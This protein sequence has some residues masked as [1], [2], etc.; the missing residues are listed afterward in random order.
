MIKCNLKSYIFAL[1]VLA[2][3]LHRGSTLFSLILA[4]A[5][6]VSCQIKPAWSISNWLDFTILL[7]CDCVFVK[8]FYID[9]VLG[10][11]LSPDTEETAAKQDDDPH[12]ATDDGNIDQRWWQSN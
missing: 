8:L 1:G 3:L 4:S 7:L 6:V 2:P 12:G 9:R 10:T 5:T 11:L